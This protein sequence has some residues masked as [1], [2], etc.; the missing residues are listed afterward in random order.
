MMRIWAHLVAGVE[1]RSRGERMVAD[2]RD[3]QLVSAGV[4]VSLALAL[5]WTGERLLALLFL[6]EALGQASLAADDGRAADRRVV[7][8][9]R[10]PLGRVALVCFAITAACRYGLA[11]ALSGHASWLVLVALASTALHLCSLVAADA[12]PDATGGLA[13]L[14]SA[15]VLGVVLM[16][17]GA[18]GAAL[19]QLGYAG[20]LATGMV[21]LTPPTAERLNIATF[22]AA[23]FCVEV[24]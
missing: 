6:S 15:L 23:I 4:F 13:L 10:S 1:R 9:R 7:Y 2:T 22:A 12:R 16:G 21:A 17:H 14:A 8:F 5:A 3:A 24:T 20:L 18:L 11:Y 19:G